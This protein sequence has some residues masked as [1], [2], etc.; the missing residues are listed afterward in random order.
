MLKVIQSTLPMLAIVYKTTCK[1]KTANLFAI[2]NCFFLHVYKQ[3]KSEF[4][5]Q[6]T[7]FNQELY[8]TLF[9]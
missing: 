4:Y 5:I 9:R 2:I 1:P 6:F 3:L 8:V 7:Y